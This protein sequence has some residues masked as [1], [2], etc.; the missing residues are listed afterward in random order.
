MTSSPTLIEPF[1]PVVAELRLA[2]ERARQDG[3]IA[4]IEARLILVLIAILGTLEALYLSWKA[5]IALPQAEPRAT[6][7]NQ[8]SARRITAPIAPRTPNRARHHA[9][10]RHT[11]A[12]QPAPDPMRHRHAAMPAPRP[13]ATILPF[14]T[15]APAAPCAR[16]MRP[17]W[18]P[19]P[20][21]GPNGP[22][23]GMPIS[24]R[25]QNNPQPPRPSRLF[26]PSR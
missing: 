9:P 12:P 15:C 2:A 10:T 7:A 5:S 18:P 23:L 25:N 6:T 8:A 17:P 20:G 16:R 26:A 21:N 1:G 22:P 19:I 13:C 4:S 11:H 24:L 3:G 14:P